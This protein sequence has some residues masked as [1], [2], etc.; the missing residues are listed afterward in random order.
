MPAIQPLD[1]EHSAP[2][3]HIVDQTPDAVIFADSDGVIRVWNG[4][5]EAVFGFSAAEA[6][7]S[8]LDIIIAE[9]FRRAHWEGYHRAMA[10]G[11]TRHGA[12]VRTTRAI[13]KDGRKLYVELSFGVVVD[14]EGA[15]LG[16]VAVGRDGTARHVSEGALRA[17]LAELGE[18]TESGAT[19]PVAGSGTAPTARR[20]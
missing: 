3:R 11:H 17:R 1:P 15:A 10:N 12:Q 13:H 7:G 18:K 4:G 14:E 20:G 2:F 8:S 6:V 19:C 9:R 16:S 5:A